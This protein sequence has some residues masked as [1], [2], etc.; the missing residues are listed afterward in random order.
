MRER[1]T[2]KGI[3]RSRPFA[4]EQPTTLHDGIYRTP[5]KTFV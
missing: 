3:T 1:E 5:V 2:L 4:I